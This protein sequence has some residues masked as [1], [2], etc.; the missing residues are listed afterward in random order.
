MVAQLVF[1]LVSRKDFALMQ[2]HTQ[3]IVTKLQA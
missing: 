1:V 2:T 3:K